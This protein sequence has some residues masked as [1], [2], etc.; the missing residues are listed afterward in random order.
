MVADVQ[1]ALLNA[2]IGGDLL[3][4]GPQVVAPAAAVPHMQHTWCLH[5]LT[6]NPIMALLY[7]MAVDAA[8]VALT[9][10]NRSIDD[11]LAEAQAK[12]AALYANVSREWLKQRYYKSIDL[13]SGP[14]TPPPRA[15]V[16]VLL[17][18]SCTSTGS[19]FC[20][21]TRAGVSLL[22][23]CAHMWLHR[24]WY[25]PHV[26]RYAG[27]LRY[28]STAYPSVCTPCYHRLRPPEW[29]APPK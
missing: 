26:A 7:S 24:S 5:S 16:R 10:T 17:R 4:H 29:A 28:R 2:K 8:A 25:K 18:T 9:D 14:E 19:C 27:R 20:Q 22:W 13:K 11:V 21:A 6:V 15:D 12:V 23:H 1:Q 3:S